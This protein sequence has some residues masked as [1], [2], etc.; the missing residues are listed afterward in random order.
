MKWMFI[1]ML[2]L[3]SACSSND[4]MPENQEEDDPIVSPPEEDVDTIRFASFNV[5]LFGNSE[6]NIENILDGPDNARVKRIAEIIQRQRPDVIALKEIDYDEAQRAVKRFRRNYL[7]VSQNGQDTIKYNYY[8]AV[9]TNTGVLSEADLDGNGNVSLPNDAYGFGNFPGQYGFAILSRYPLDVDNARSF[10]ELLWKDMPD[11][12]LPETAGGESYYS[13]EALDVFRLSSKNHLDVG[14]VVPNGSPIHILVSHPTPPVF[15]GA[16]DRNGKR[17]HDEIR[18][19]ADYIS[20]EAYMT[21]DD[22]NTGGLAGGSSFVV[23]GDLNADPLDGDSTNDAISQLLDH[24]AV[25]QAVVSGDFVPSSAGG[26]EHNQQAGNQGDPAYDTSFFGLRIDY[27]LPSAD[28]EVVGSGVF[29]PAS[30]DPL[31][32]LV[33]NEASSDHL[34]VWVDVIR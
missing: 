28:L 31:S 32:Y 1:V 6:G 33:E 11:A 18:L 24:S 14:V 26:A 29:W 19:W 22:G 9:P 25:N 34:M 7:E 4:A 30:T 16:E 21:D 17:N 2:L 5:S 23:M 3:G 20:G 12:L 27:V 8:C 10:R 13:E 15:D